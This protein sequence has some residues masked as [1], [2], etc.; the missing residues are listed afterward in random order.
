MSATMFLTSYSC[1]DIIRPT[2]FF[3]SRLLF[4]T[5]LLALI[6]NLLR[7]TPPMSV[8]TIYIS[9]RNNSDKDKGAPVL[10]P[11]SSSMSYWTNGHP[12]TPEDVGF[13]THLSHHSGSS[14]PC[15]S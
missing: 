10:P 6:R 13:T 12:Q 15:L 8:S 5:L 3:V 14:C 11:E 4:S 9:K 1:P 7:P 2:A